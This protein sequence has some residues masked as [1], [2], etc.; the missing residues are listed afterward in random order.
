MADNKISIDKPV[1]SK[2]GGALA[3]LWRKILTENNYLPVLDLLVAKYIRENDVTSGRVENAKRKTKSSLI[4]N[5]TSSDM[6]IKTLLD[7]MF[8][9]LK[10]PLVTITITIKHRTGQET[11][12]S[13]SIASKEYTDTE[14]S[15]SAK[16]K[17]DDHD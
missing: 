11:H 6:T 3:K 12:H 2:E 5:I 9:F 13:I 8:N 16:H 10:V 15:E 4:A 1:S 14:T 17:K 7:L